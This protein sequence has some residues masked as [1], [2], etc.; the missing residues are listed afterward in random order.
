MFDKTSIYEK[1][2]LILMVQIDHLNGEILGWAINCL[3][4]IGALNVQTIAT[5]TK[6]N[7]P[8]Y[9]LIVDIPVKCFDEIEA[10]FVEELATTGWHLIKSHHRH[11]ATEAVIKEIIFKN[12]DIKIRCSLEG[13][14]VKGKP[15]TVRP[16]NRSCIAIYEKLR[17]EGVHSIS[18]QNLCSQL[19]AILKNPNEE[20]IQI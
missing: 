9:I 5:I 3:Y 1:E 11:I 13:K 16:E 2:G 14:Q 10:F 7:R 15:E 20:E 4:E 18:F 19:T 6:K 8:G 12:D 17:K